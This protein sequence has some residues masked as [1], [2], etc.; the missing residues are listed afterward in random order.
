M[1][2]LFQALRAGGEK[3]TEEE[4]DTVGCCNLRVQHVELVGDKAHPKVKFDFL[5]KDS[6]RYVDSCHFNPSPTAPCSRNIDRM[7][8]TVRH[9]RLLNA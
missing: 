8:E 9:P 3:D 6:I 1:V 4:A 7:P 5:G 2:A